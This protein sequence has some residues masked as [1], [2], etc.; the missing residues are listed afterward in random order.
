[1]RVVKWTLLCMLKIVTGLNRG[2][3]KIWSWKA[4]RMVCRHTVLSMQMAE[5]RCMVYW[6]TVLD[7]GESAV[8][9]AC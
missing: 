5:V 4:F 6:V 9:M 3:G 7:G 8:S 2:C 1:M